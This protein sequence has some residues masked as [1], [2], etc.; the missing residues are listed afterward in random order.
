MTDIFEADV[1]S[2]VGAI[3][4]DAVA[5]GK[6]TSAL[7]ERTLAMQANYGR[8]R[9]CVYSNVALPFEGRVDSDGDP[10]HS[11]SEFEGRAD[12]ADTLIM[13]WLVPRS[14]GHLSAQV[15]LKAW[16]PTGAVTRFVFRDRGRV[17]GEVQLIGNG[18][19]QNVSGTIQFPPSLSEI[20]RVELWV[21]GSNSDTLA[22]TAVIGTPNQWTATTYSSGSG[23]SAD[24]WFNRDEVATSIANTW[25]NE[26]ALGGYRFVFQDS[27]GA[28]GGGLIGSAH[29]EDLDLSRTNYARFTV[30][31]VP[32]IE[33]D[34]VTTVV[35]RLRQ[36]GR[37]ST[38]QVNIVPVPRFALYNVAILGDE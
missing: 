7:L 26:L 18:S 25:T 34:A 22:S 19:V 35:H 21:R 20:Q 10:S 12:R 37:R 16:S 6:P 17:L 24:T 8:V 27:G 30:R 4:S 11:Y 13:P 29:I 5:A 2:A 1:A 3:D 32:E 38:L 14:P 9:P 28:G 36:A 33:G 31:M 15:R 23:G